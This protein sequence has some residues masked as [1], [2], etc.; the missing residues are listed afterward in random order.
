VVA[1]TPEEEHQLRHY[2]IKAP[3]SV[4][5]NGVITPLADRESNIGRVFREIHTIPADAPVVG[6]L[7]RL[8]PKKGLHSLV[9]AFATLP[10]AS[11][12]WLVIAGDPFQDARYVEEVKALAQEHGVGSQ[13]VWP[14]FLD[15]EG[16]RG[17][18]SAI[19]IFS[20]ATESEGMALTALE[21][22]AAGVPTLVSDRCY[23][24]EAAE[25]GALVQVAFDHRAL[26]AAFRSLLADSSRRSE[27]GNAGHDY[28]RLKHSWP[29][30]AGR[31]VD[32]YRSGLDS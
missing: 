21:A 19:T 29:S 4:I 27:L 16:K 25:A 3:V 2:G 28:V 31:I 18:W 8:V 23:M 1:L 32:L 10:N 30:I 13:I 11:E 5:P 14:G 12:A 15:E 17:F 6:F 26:G 22:M 7:G 20:H 24:G 9:R